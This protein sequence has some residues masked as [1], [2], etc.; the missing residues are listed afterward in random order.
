MALPVVLL[1]EVFSNAVLNHVNDLMI[2]LG[3]PILR[4]IVTDCVYLL[5]GCHRARAAQQWNLP[6][7]II[8]MPYNPQADNHRDLYD[9][10]GGDRGFTVGWIMDPTNRE[11][12]LIKVD[13][14]IVTLG[15]P[16]G[17]P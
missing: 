5:E 1:H 7:R 6:L 2:N 13:Y 10:I 3:P 16:L 4:A 11:G 17:L 12:R 14:E 15:N 9:W 8:E